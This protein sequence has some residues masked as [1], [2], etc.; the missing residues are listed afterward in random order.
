[1]APMFQFFTI[2]LQSFLGFS[3]N[4]KRFEVQCLGYPL[5]NFQLLMI[6]SLPCRCD[7]ILVL[8]LKRIV[9]FDIQRFGRFLNEYPNILLRSYCLK[10]M[11]KVTFIKSVWITF[12]ALFHC[13]ELNM[14]NKMGTTIKSVTFV[15]TK[16]CTKL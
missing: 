13:T 4:H 2:I 3:S 5:A 16:K 8:R 1:M 6:S 12:T 7:N 9:I 10:M 14:H 15:F 11:D